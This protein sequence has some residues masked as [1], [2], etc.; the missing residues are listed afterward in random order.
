[1]IKIE[2]L[3]IPEPFSWRILKTLKFVTSEALLK[4]RRSGALVGERAIF[5]LLLR[6]K[7]NRK[8]I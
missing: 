3:G 6:G 4:A 2:G 5:E 8:K 7:T 1:M